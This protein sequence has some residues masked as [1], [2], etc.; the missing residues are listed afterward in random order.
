[1]SHSMGP[2]PHVDF[3]SARTT[4]FQKALTSALSAPP[5]APAN[6]RR[7]GLRLL[8]Y[9][10]GSGAKCC[11][12]SSFSSRRA[13]SFLWPRSVTD[14]SPQM[15]PPANVKYNSIRPIMST[16]DVIFSFA[17]LVLKPGVIQSSSHFVFTL[18][19]MIFPSGT[20]DS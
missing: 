1:M 15:M 13:Q 7:I 5:Y 4:Y 8:A 16:V 12:L 2:E 17:V 19:C 6:I 14:G 9:W 20:I 11:S 3:R 18:F 10:A